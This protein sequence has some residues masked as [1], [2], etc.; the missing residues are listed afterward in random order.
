MKIT[1]VVPHIPDAQ[2]AYALL[3]LVRHIVTAGVKGPDSREYHSLPKDTPVNGTEAIPRFSEPTGLHNIRFCHADS[4][5]T[6]YRMVFHFTGGR[7]DL[8]RGTSA[9]MRAFRELTATI[10]AFDAG[11]FVTVARVTPGAAEEITQRTFPDVLAGQ[12]E[13]E[14]VGVEDELDLLQLQG[15]RLDSIDLNSFLAAA[16]P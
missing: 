2:R 16:A 11:G 3:N 10:I 4:T 14:F 12:L 7:E 9:C 6:S 8:W 5:R 15:S 13:E 1:V